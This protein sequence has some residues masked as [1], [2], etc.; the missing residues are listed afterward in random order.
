LILIKINRS[1]LASMQISKL[2]SQ[3]DKK[4]CD[5]CQ[6]DQLVSCFVLWYSTV[7]WVAASTNMSC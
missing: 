5:N 2:T 3:A 4:F 7:R 6:S 1:V